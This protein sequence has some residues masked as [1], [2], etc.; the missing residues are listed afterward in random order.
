MSRYSHVVFTKHNERKT[1][2]GSDTKEEASSNSRGN[3]S[4]NET[5]SE[6]SDQSDNETGT[7]NNMTE[8]VKCFTQIVII[9][10]H[11]ALDYI[12]KIDYVLQISLMLLKSRHRLMLS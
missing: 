2:M 10:T 5:D 4:E 6:S 3:V 8:N 1:E 7:L 12:I 9:Y 11:T